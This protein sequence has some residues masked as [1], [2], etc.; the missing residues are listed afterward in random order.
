MGQQRGPVAD[1][2]RAQLGGGDCGEFAV[3]TRG[4]EERE[5]KKRESAERQE[6]LSEVIL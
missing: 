1:G 6:R 4:E 3:K 2:P 5:K